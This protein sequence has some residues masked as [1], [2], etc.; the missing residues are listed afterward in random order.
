MS[1]QR[2][3]FGLRAIIDA[4]TRLFGRRRRGP[5]GAADC[6]LQDPVP[7]KDE[8]VWSYITSPRQ[9]VDA[10][11][12]AGIPDS[13]TR[14]FTDKIRDGRF[15][16]EEWANLFPEDK[17]RVARFIAR[18]VQDDRFTALEWSRLPP[19][20]Q[21]RVLQHLPPGVRPFHT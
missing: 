3:L 1:K 5:A 21:E 17:E 9:I 7:S 12:R 2:L 8:E 14:I 20:G 13:L 18:L 19:D 11:I 15:T 6:R 10:M 16:S 4:M